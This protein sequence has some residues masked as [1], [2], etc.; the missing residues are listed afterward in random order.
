MAES[1]GMSTVT[2]CG[3]V[4]ELSTIFNAVRHAKILLLLFAASL[5]GCTNLKPIAMDPETLQDNIRDGKMVHEG[6]TIRVV[7]KDG[8][9]HLLVVAGVDELTIRGHATGAPPGAIVI[10]IPI[11]DV[12]TLEEEKV[13][14]GEAVAGSIGVVTIAV[15]VAIIIAPI[16]VLG[17]LGV[18]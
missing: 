3:R 2:A 14:A 10:D 8:V 12:L 5:S 6:D 1:N 4:A 17:A 7:T 9:S 16:A 11:D 18:I 13:H 15:A